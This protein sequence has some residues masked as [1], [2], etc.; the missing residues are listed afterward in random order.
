ML[1]DDGDMCEV[2]TGCEERALM[3]EVVWVALSVA[4]VTA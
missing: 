1:V 2:M 3:R 4:L